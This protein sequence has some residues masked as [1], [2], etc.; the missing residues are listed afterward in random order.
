MYRI[1][2]IIFILFLYFLYGQIMRLTRAGEYAIRCVLYLSTQEEGKVASRKEIAQEMDIPNPFL[3]KI[4]QQL[5][6]SGIL[7]ILQGPKGG[8][9]L[10][11]SPGQINLLDVIEA[12]MGEIFLSDCVLRSG[13]CRRSDTCAV[14]YIWLAAKNQLRNTLRKATFAKLV[15]SDTYITE[16]IPIEI[17]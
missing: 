10:A 15:K 3:G 17:D 11:V 8:F 7:D 16:E 1:K 5:A 9:R 2:R 4:A 12:I 13:A 14:H 6:R